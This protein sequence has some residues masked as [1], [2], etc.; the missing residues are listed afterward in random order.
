[1]V[2]EQPDHEHEGL[3]PA[4]DRLDAQLC[5]LSRALGRLAAVELYALEQLYDRFPFQETQRW[6]TL[7]EAAELLG[8]HLTRM[9]T[10]C[11]QRGLTGFPAYKTEGIVRVRV[12]DLYAWFATYKR[13]M[14]NTSR[15]WYAAD[16]LR[17]RPELLSAR[18]RAAGHVDWYEDEWL[19]D[20]R[21][22]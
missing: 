22:T 11:A 2:N 7:P 6:I 20:G 16:G 8:V 18:L 1:M 13:A 21:F 14:L 5:A 4:L 10:W 15:R 17:K 9:R 19:A 12:P 3:L